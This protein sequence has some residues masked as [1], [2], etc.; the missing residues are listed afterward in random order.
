MRLSDSITDLMG[1]TETNSRKYGG[2]RNWHV[3]P[4]GLQRAR[5][6]LETIK[7]AIVVVTILS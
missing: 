4:S 5:H 2:H 6:N 1:I 7:K 3:W